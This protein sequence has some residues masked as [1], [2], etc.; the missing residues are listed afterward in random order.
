MR[1]SLKSRSAGASLALGGWRG[2][3]GVVH[4]NWPGA[5]VDQKPGSMVVGLAEPDKSLGSWEATCLQGLRDPIRNLGPEEPPWVMKAGQLWDTLKAW[6]RK[7]W[8]V[9]CQGSAWSCGLLG[10]TKALFYF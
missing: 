9:W 4:R 6:V 7:P 2:S 5:G 10:T 1:T 3:R 8:V